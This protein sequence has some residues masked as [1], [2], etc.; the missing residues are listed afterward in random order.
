[1]PSP[2]SISQDQATSSA[3]EPFPEAA[4][5]SLLRVGAPAPGD[6][7]GARPPEGLLPTADPSERPRVEPKPPPRTP[8][9]RRSGAIGRFARETLKVAAS[10]LILGIAA[11]A[12]LVIWDT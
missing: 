8:A 1:M 10:L 4:E 7:A 11:L 5:R 9:P 3:A 6:E 12:A 2:R